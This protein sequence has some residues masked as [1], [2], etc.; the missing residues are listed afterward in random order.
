MQTV[1]QGVSSGRAKS[2]VT[3]WEKWLDFTSDLG[4]DP[5][6]QIFQD[7]VPILQVSLH[8]VRE[9][10]LAANKNPV[11]ARSAEDYV[12]AVAQA[13]LTLGTQDPRLNSANKTDF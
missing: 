6:L 3:T 9:G 13:F 1:A 4:L 8:R 12:R 5:F 2:T 7:K 11:R 10:E